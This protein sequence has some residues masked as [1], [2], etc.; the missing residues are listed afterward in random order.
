MIKKIVVCVLFIISAAGCS[1]EPRES[2]GM[3]EFTDMAGRKIMI[4]VTI[5]KAYC[6]SP[7]GTTVVYTFNPD[8]LAG[9]N[10]T[11]NDV[12]G[13]F[14]PE[15]YKK[16]P[17]LGGWFGKSAGAN[18]EML[19]KEHPDVIIS[20]VTTT[21]LFDVDKARALGEKTG[22]PAALFY[23]R[24]MDDIPE[25][26]TR[27]GELFSD[28][29]R[30]KVLSEFSAKIIKQAAQI[31]SSIPE[32]KRKK[33]YYAEGMKGLNTE[34][35][36]SM[37]A[38]LIPLCGTENVVHIR[39]NNISGYGNTPVSIEQVVVWDP[40]VILISD[41][42]GK[43]GGAAGWRNILNSNPLWKRIKAVKE[44][45]IFLIPHT[46]FQWID[47]PPSVNRLAGLLWLPA[48]MY[49][50]KCGYDLKKE[51]RKF[52]SVFYHYELTDDELNRLVRSNIYQ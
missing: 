35:E 47:R 6:P 39:E 26:Y 40:E 52:Y 28:D 41:Y 2:H 49:P 37:H 11:I 18:T 31:R 24:T 23:L 19:I 13:E 3:R 20:I 34:P 38:E 25:L 51:M 33:L 48:I 15:K 14:I 45:Q 29:A 21:E 46:P 36:K 8:L 44:K 27:L 50:E 5:H 9:W 4:P 12:E 7:M 10:Y 32:D 17:V 30:A 43:D 1:R 16:I 42:L 22:I